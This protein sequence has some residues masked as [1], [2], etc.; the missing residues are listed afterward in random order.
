M[1]HHHVD[2]IGL[3]LSA[4]GI[5]LLLLASRYGDEKLAGNSYQIIGAIISVAAHFLIWVTRNQH[6]VNDTSLQNIL[7]HC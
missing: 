7:P 1:F 2:W 4:Y 3:L 6:K 5:L